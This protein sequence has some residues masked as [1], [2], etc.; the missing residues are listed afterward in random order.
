MPRTGRSRGAVGRQGESSP[1]ID[2]G[3]WKRQFPDTAWTVLA[4]A[5]EGDQDSIGEFV[6]RYATPMFCFLRQSGLTPEDAKDL[7][8]DMLLKVAGGKF[9][10]HLTLQE[11]K[12]RSYLLQSLRHLMVS[13]HRKA[14]SGK[15]LPPEWQVSLDK[16]LEE[17][18][19]YVEPATE[20]TPTDAFARREA[21]EVLNKVIRQVQHECEAAGLSV[22]FSIFAARYLG[23]W[24]PEQS[25]PFKN[26]EELLGTTAAD[27]CASIKWSRI[28]AAHDVSEQRAQNMC[29]TVQQRFR[30]ALRQEVGS[31]NLCEFI[32]AF[33]R[34]ICSGRP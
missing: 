15:R 24:S 9:F 7:V 8:Q 25:G 32:A 12:F 2:S 22:H 10:A 4:E 5:Q 31:D 34:A 29:K 19:P 18:G 14:T 20:D 17:A 33:A 1:L 26:T 28:G 6:R 16:V 13:E 21:R 11:S 23:S 30:K 3:A 27:A